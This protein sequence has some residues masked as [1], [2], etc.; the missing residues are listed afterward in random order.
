MGKR[1]EFTEGQKFGRFTV[2]REV[3]P[4]RYPSGDLCRRILCKC[5]CGN[6]KII[7]AKNLRQTLAVT[8]MSR[9]AYILLQNVRMQKD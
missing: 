2:I 7:A 8:A 6:V 9:S 3:E 1:Q 4:D 5:S